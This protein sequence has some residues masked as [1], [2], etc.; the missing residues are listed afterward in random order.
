MDLIDLNKR[1]FFIHKI[2]LRKSEPKHKTLV[3]TKI[4]SV[5]FNGNSLVFKNTHY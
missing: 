1:T 2:Q 5:H 4:C 3:C